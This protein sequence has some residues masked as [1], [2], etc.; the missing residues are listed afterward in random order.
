MDSTVV[1]TKHIIWTFEIFVIFVSDLGVDY[2]LLILILSPRSSIERLQ[3]LLRDDDEIR[4]LQ[5]QFAQPQNDSRDET[6][7]SLRLPQKSKEPHILDLEKLRARQLIALAALP[8]AAIID[9]MGIYRNELAKET[10]HYTKYKM[11]EQATNARRLYN[12]RYDQNQIE[13]QVKKR[14]HEAALTRAKEE[15]TR[16][17]TKYRA[18]LSPAQ[19]DL[20]NEYR[21]TTRRLSAPHGECGISFEPVI[22]KGENEFIMLEKISWSPPDPDKSIPGKH[23]SAPGGAHLWLYKQVFLK[24]LVASNGPENP[25]NRDPLYAPPELN[26]MKYQYKFY[27][28]ATVQGHALSLQLCEA[29]EEFSASLKLSP[30]NSKTDKPTQTSSN[31]ISQF[32]AMSDSHDTNAGVSSMGMF[33]SSSAARVYYDADVEQSNDTRTHATLSEQALIENEIIWRPRM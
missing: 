21:E 30:A 33:G 19:Q 32:P 9:D 10:A 26:G 7:E 4:N 17:E 31:S 18:T 29:I 15:I 3:V 5:H 24:L 6:P 16:L 20:Y 28:Y 22:C 27:N 1:P 12:K 11:E 25:Y 8:K 23:V 13:D 2:S 14:Q